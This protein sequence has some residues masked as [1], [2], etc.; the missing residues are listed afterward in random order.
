MESG[1]VAELGA[2]CCLTAS[3]VKRKRLMMLRPETEE[4][5][6]P[7]QGGIEHNNRIGQTVREWVPQMTAGALV[8]KR[9]RGGSL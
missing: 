6:P 1:C 8:A 9:A 3:A 5:G 7:R 2:Q 4:G